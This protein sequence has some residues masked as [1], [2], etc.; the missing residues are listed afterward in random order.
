MHVHVLGICGYAT[1]GAAGLA[2]ERGDRVTGSDDHAYPPMSDAVTAAGI[3]WE[4]R[5]DPANLDRWGVPDLV[6]VGNQTRPANLELEAV[7]LRGIPCVSEIEFYVGLAGDRLRLTVCGTHGKTTTSALLV[8]ILERAGMDPGF[9]LGSTSLDL[10]GTSRLGTGPFIFEGDEYTSAPWDARPKFLHTNPQGACVTRLELDHPDV[11]AS[12]DAYREP[13]IELASTMP[14]DGLLA[15]CADD[16]ECLALRD[17]ATSVVVTYGTN[18]ESGWRIRDAREQDG[19]QRF[20]VERNHAE[21]LDVLLTFPGVHNAQNACAALILAEFAGVDPAIAVAAC[22]DFRGP[23]RRFEI[24]GEFGRVAVVD[25]YAHHPTEVAAAIAA[26]RQRYP[27]RR[28]IAIHTPHTY[29]RVSR[30]LEDYRRSFTGADVVVI[31]PIEEARERGMPKTV[32]SQDVADRAGGA[33]E[34]HVVTSSDQ[35]IGLMTRITRP[36]DVLLV[37]SLGGFDKLA[38]RLRDALEAPG[39]RR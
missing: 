20:S 27:R 35:A 30:L 1:F 4:N 16:P 33:G 3:E 39:V 38:P 11:Y 23:A 14:A 6:V 21:P 24:L 8:H 29:S 13:F 32:S 26:A 18:S 12:L 19:M 7:R 9:R 34:V 25:D 37:L 2:L 22:A 17:A 10:G 36:G 28:L 15:L 31:G 5:S